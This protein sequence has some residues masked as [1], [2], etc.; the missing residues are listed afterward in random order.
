MKK[1]QKEEICRPIHTLL[2]IMDKH[3]LDYALFG[4]V[5][6]YYIGLCNLVIY[7]ESKG[8]IKNTETSILLLYLKNH[9]PWTRKRYAN[10]HNFWWH[11]TLVFPR[12]RYIKRRLRIETRLYKKRNETN[13]DL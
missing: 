5:Y 13:M 4:N 6:G 11:P 12:K 3:L 10:A 7:L 2:G 9:I 8:F 1:K